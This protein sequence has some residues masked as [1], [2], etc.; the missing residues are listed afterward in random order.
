MIDVRDLSLVVGG[1][2]VLDGVDLR[3]EPGELV[4]L[5]GPNGAGKSTL[6]KIISGDIAPTAGTV[7]IAGKPLADHG[8]ISLAKRRAVLAQETRMAFPFEAREVVALG[9]SPHGEGGDSPRI[10]DLAMVETGTAAFR[11]RLITTLSGGESQRVHLARVLAQIWDGPEPR[12]LLLDEPTSSLD[13]G[14]QHAMLRHAREMADE[15]CAVLCVLHDL[16]LAAQYAHRLVLLGQGRVVAAGSATE[17][18]TPTLLRTLFSVEAVILPH[19]TLGFPVVI[20][21]GE[22]TKDPP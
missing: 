21:S 9:R 11:E 14:H 20:A 17:V 1:R 4:V 3:V 16:N 13:L 5:G 12:I 2:R 8:A 19:P 6:L 7:S 15:G 22:A 10:V 18:L